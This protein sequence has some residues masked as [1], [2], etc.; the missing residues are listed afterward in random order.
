M[1]RQWEMAINYT[2]IAVT[3]IFVIEMLLK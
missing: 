3:A 1:N 2:N